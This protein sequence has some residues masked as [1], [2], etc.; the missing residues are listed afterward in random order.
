MTVQEMLEQAHDTATQREPSELASELQ[1]LLGQRMVAFALGDR[2]PK[3]IGRYARGER[4]PDDAAV[5]RLVDLYTLVELLENGM[6]RKAI[7]SWMLG[8]NPRLRG[9][10]PIEAIHE[11]RQADVERAARAFLANR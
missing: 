7:R 1:A 3:T 11:G 5:R 2:H 10:A 8:S 4:S 9:R 6:R